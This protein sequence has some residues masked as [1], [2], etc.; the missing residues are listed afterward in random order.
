MGRGLVG[1]WPTMRMEGNA[2]PRGEPAWRRTRR[3]VMMQMT[4]HAVSMRKSTYAVGGQH[5]YAPS[6]GASP[7]LP[8]KSSRQCRPS[9]MRSRRSARNSKAS[10]EHVSL[11]TSCRQHVSRYPRLAGMDSAVL[12]GEGLGRRRGLGGA[13][14]SLFCPK[15]LATIDSLSRLPRQH[16]S[17][18]ARHA[19]PAKL[20]CRGG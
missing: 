6:C 17:D 9:R 3:S 18:T 2:G 10:S 4:V 20:G 8:P 5:M 19:T 12:G 15:K 16:D 13:Q 7:T 11:G 14:S 1:R